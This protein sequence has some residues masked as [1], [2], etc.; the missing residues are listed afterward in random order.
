M[1]DTERENEAEKGKLSSERYETG[2][3]EEK[4]KAYQFEKYETRKRGER[5]GN[6]VRLKDTERENVAREEV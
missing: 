4:W 5:A 3:G 2:N 6:F 1:K